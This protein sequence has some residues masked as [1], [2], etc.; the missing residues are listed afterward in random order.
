MDREEYERCDAQQGCYRD[1]QDAMRNVIV[2]AHTIA[3]TTD[4][5]KETLT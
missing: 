5:I 3:V 1:G 2:H 4:R